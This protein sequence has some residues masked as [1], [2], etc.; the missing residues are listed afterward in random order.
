[1]LRVLPLMAMEDE[2]LH[3]DGVE[4][5]VMLAMAP[6]AT[7]EESDVNVTNM[8]CVVALNEGMVIPLPLLTNSWGADV[9]A[10]S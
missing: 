3:G 7:T 4:E 1:M 6:D 9:L 8:F 5:N 10:P 2:L